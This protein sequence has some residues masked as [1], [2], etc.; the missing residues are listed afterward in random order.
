MLLS[1]LVLPP[2]S[3]KLTLYLVALV[4]ICQVV[5]DKD[6]GLPKGTICNKLYPSAPTPYRYLNSGAWIGYA[7]YAEKLLAAVVEVSVMG[8]REE[9]GV[10]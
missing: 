9:G 7:S 6:K 5:K 3:C 10:E 2:S 8:G 1:P 4:G